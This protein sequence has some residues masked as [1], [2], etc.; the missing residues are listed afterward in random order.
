M[1]PTIEQV[2]ALIADFDK[3]YRRVC[4]S[5]FLLTHGVGITS[6]ETMG[7]LRDLVVRKPQGRYEAAH[8]LRPS[9]DD[10]NI[11]FTNDHAAID[12]AYDEFDVL[13]SKVLERNPQNYQWVVPPTDSRYNDDEIEIGILFTD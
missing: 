7:A 3:K 4:S 10:L 8:V 13:I 11:E 9:L 12:A 1:K 6:S 5:G 2:T